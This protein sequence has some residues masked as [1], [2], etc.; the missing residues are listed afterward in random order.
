[1]FIFWWLAYLSKFTGQIVGVR[2]TEANIL[3][4]IDNHILKHILKQAIHIQLGLVTLI[5]R[6]MDL[7]L[8]WIGFPIVIAQL[9]FWYNCGI[10]ETPGWL[11]PFAR[12]VSRYLCL[13]SIKAFTRNVWM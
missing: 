9:S 13:V 4:L 3:D 1:L 5:E 11:E 2:Q 10:S 12:C 8:F 6:I 7:S